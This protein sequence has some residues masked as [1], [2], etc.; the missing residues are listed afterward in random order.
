M[1]GL[2]VTFAPVDDE[3]PHGYFRRLAMQNGFSSWRAVLSTA[4]LNPSMNAMWKNAKQLERTLGLDAKW[5]AKLLDQATQT[6]GLNAPYFLRA[7]CEPLCPKCLVEDEYLRHAWS[8]CFVTACPMHSCALLDICPEC[9][10]Q[11][12]NFRQ[13][14]AI[15]NCGFDLRFAKTHAASPNEIWLSARLAGN[16][17]P[18]AGIEEFGLINDYSDLAKLVFQL[19]VRFDASSIAKAA[20]VSRPRT[21]A[22]S[23]AFLQPFLSLLPDWRSR[24]AAHVTARLLTS[25]DDGSSLASRLGPWFANIQSLCLKP[26][27]FQIFWETISN[28]LFEKFDGVLRGQN[29]LT[30]SPGVSRQYLS[31][32]E[33]AKLIGISVPL[34]QR[35]IDEKSVA[36]KFSR[37]GTSYRVTMISRAE[38]M[39]IKE[40][41]SAWIS[42]PAAANLLGISDMTLAAL[43]RARVIEYDKDWARSFGKAG[44]VRA[45]VIPELIAR[46]EGWITEMPVDDVFEFNELTAKRTVDIKALA[47]LH[48]AIF[49]G[50]LRPTL[51]RPK[52]GLGGFVFAKSEVS[53]ILGSAALAKSLTLPQ[54]ER[55]TGVKYESLRM[56][57]LL[58]LLPS[59][60]VTL[61][62]RSAS[63]VSF[64]AFIEFRKSWIPVADIAY[65]LGRK[66]SAVTARLLQERIDI[67][68]QT[69]PANGARRGGLV[70]MRDIAGLALR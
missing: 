56:W 14:I 38:A 42:E 47:T 11:L 20:K 18:V 5:L 57:V 6:S 68:G 36:A 1:T 4:G 62:G 30:P 26:P 25:P 70:S 35:G 58:G 31:I 54:L 49:E 65:A 69:N 19:V 29:G 37:E 10:T 2:L 23:K 33:A 43:A 34:L 12:D 7:E 39:R 64:E 55:V 66:S 45:N 41:R 48:K 8:H 51:R 52:P 13:S 67:V 40:V 46:L 15:C 60:D 9:A 44:P 50:A 24:L 3:S 17:I 27:R 32:S 63:V 61:Q 22:E 59:E 28:T 53:K 16:P 21:V